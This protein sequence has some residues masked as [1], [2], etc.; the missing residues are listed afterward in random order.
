MKYKTNNIIEII[1]HV[2]LWIVLTFLF[3]HFNAMSFH[4]LKG[5]L[6][7]VP[8]LFGTFINVLLFYLNLFYLFPKY[9]SKKL[10]VINYSL[11]IIIV[12]ILLSVLE[13]TFDYLYAVSKTKNNIVTLRLANFLQQVL[14]T[15]FSFYYLFFTALL[16]TG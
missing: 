7:D 4:Y 16:G 12:V 3:I 8:L 2:F 13:N 10:T 15:C 14:S 5:D 6:M 11:W 1:I 9:K